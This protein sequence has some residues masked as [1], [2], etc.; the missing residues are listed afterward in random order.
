[1]TFREFYP[2]DGNY[3]IYGVPSSY[4]IVV[5]C[6]HAIETDY[7]IRLTL[8][9]DWYV[10]ETS[11]CAVGGHSGLYTCTAVKDSRTITVTNFLSST[12]SA[13]TDLT[14]TVGS[15]RNPHLME[16]SYSI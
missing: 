4:T 15:I 3:M 11:N 5:S 9:E 13:N 7:G 12:W 10:V 2:T 16:K 1:M 6:E 14:L 8:P